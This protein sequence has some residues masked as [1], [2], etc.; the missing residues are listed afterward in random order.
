MLNQSKVDFKTDY[1][2]Y[3]AKAIKLIH[4]PDTRE[5]VLSL[6]N[7]NDP[8]S[9]VAKAAVVVMQKLDAASRASGM[10]IGDSVKVLGAAEIVKLIVEFGNAARKFQL[11]EE[12]VDLALSVAVQDYVKQE[13]AAGRLDGKK[14]KVAMEADIRKLPPAKRKEVQQAQYRIAQIAR[15]YNGGRGMQPAPAEV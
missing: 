11:D 9:K 5:A 6:L 15:K 14:L 8:V 12:L 4:S 10:E 1:A 2:Q 3:V 13:M 7:N